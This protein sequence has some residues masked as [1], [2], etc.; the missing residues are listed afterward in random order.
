MLHLYGGGQIAIENDRWQLVGINSVY[1]EGAVPP[2]WGANGFVLINTVDRTGRPSYAFKETI[3][4]GT[5][6]HLENN[7]TVG[8][9]AIRGA[10]SP[11]GATQLVLDANVSIEKANFN[12]YVPGRPRFRMYLSGR[13][14]APAVRIDYQSDLE[15]QEFKVRFGIE[16][17]HYK[18]FFNKDNTYSNPQ[19]IS[20]YVLTI[21][22]TINDIKIMD[23]V[24]NNLS[25][26]NI[27]KTIRNILGNELNNSYFYDAPVA[28]NREAN[29]TVYGFNDDGEWEIYDSRNSDSN[30]K[31]DR[32]SVGRGYWIKMTNSHYN[33]NNSKHGIL[34]G[35]IGISNDAYN[36]VGNGWN[37]LSFNNSDIRYSPTAVFIPEADYTTNIITISYKF[38]I[39]SFR[40]GAPTS[41]E[42]ARIINW[43]SERLRITDGSSMKL[44]AYPASKST[45]L[46]TAT[47]GIV[48]ISND[49]FETNS[50]NAVSLAGMP[51]TDLVYRN[52]KS[53][54]YGEFMLAAEV[55]D[56]NGSDV[57]ESFTVSMPLYNP[58]EIS[59]TD[60]NV[61][62]LEE[63]ANLILQGF[64]TAGNHPDSSI[65]DANS[66]VYF[67]D[68]DMDDSPDTF[69]FA[70]TSRFSI[71]DSTY[72]K[73]FSN[74]SNGSFVIKGLINARAT[75]INQINSLTSFTSVS[76][77]NL[78]NSQFAISSNRV[79]DLDLLETA[80]IT[81]FEDNPDISN[82][83]N[84]T[85]GQGAIGRVY[86]HKNM[87]L[88]V[89]T[90]DDY[91][92]SFDA[93]EGIVNR[94]SPFFIN[95]QGSPMW[96]PDFPNGGP[97]NIFSNFDK[98]ITGILTMD[99][100]NVNGN[101]DFWS[102]T[103]V[104]KDPGTWF[105]VKDAQQLFNIKK[106]K[107][108]WVNIKNLL[109][110]SL[111]VNKDIIYKKVS[112]PHFNNT[113]ELVIAQRICPVTNH[114]NHEFS[115][116]VD[117]IDPL[118]ND[119]YNISA[120]IMGQSYPL[121]SRGSR[122]SLRINDWN[123]NLQ[124]SIEG[125]SSPDVIILDIF[126]GL[127]NKLKNSDNLISFTK[128]VIPVI[129]W[130][131]DNGDIIIDSTSPYE[132]HSSPILD[133]SP[134]DSIVLEN[135]NNLSSVKSLQWENTDG[136]YTLIRIVA[137][138]QT[139]KFYSDIQPIYYSPLKSGHVLN[140][141]SNGGSDTIPYSY[142]RNDI[143]RV[144]GIESDN[145]VELNNV[146]DKRILMTYFPN[147]KEG[148]QRLAA[149]AGAT[150][151]YLSIG[152][153]VIGYITYIPT[154]AGRL[155]YIYYEEELYQGMF[156]SNDTYNFGGSPYD[157]DNVDGEKIEYNTYATNSQPIIEPLDI[158]KPTPGI[159]GGD[160]Q[161]PQT[162]KKVPPPPQLLLPR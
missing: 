93:G 76:Y 151:M 75:N 64:I 117:G 152:T 12:D 137:K 106:E 41:L 69:L 123:M 18:A 56:L 118:K 97:I 45:S 26:N 28:A 62:T 46:T 147:E 80:G 3:K 61:S 2:I 52:A 33:V 21:D 87:L 126:D 101:E 133:T 34:I 86:T 103:D 70:S 131:K 85:L 130:N 19:I 109:L 77:I 105:E 153:N 35:D 146:T 39:N 127:G 107:G 162:G 37:L 115:I 59:I 72:T 110:N 79:Q 128:P 15:G 102:I 38:N 89:L 83:G 63:E 82:S 32:F 27:S 49:K 67:I 121:R 24:D 74:I 145:G 111:S 17:I 129:S 57:N 155:F 122:F 42:A 94:P 10:F 154:Y 47:K 156:S 138:N 1:A 55:G 66:S 65:Q 142:I 71:F 141:E 84:R 44:R 51:L 81:L 113:V 91:N 99:S 50:T 96:A 5:E 98:E 139:T 148:V 149:F 114:I 125:I 124:E 8:L 20:P 136:N 25:D 135:T 7:A 92:S 144:N 112:T 40:V 54:Y 100:S 120:T 95:L 58:R 30:N 48:I 53:T 157:L 159:G 119:S 31:I 160:N 90:A 78:G 6:E 14:I 36:S 29:I 13:D 140:V 134:D 43:T 158:V 161:N 22:N 9:L 4:T 60:L 73:V 104:T 150:T 16:G 132:I 23:M 11:S 88:S 143:L 68:L 108:Y 116:E